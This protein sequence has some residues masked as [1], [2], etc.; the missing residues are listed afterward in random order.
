MKDKTGVNG[1]ELLPFH[2]IRVCI[3]ILIRRESMMSVYT[4]DLI[5]HDVAAEKWIIIRVLA[6]IHNDKYIC[7]HTYINIC[8]YVYIY[9]HDL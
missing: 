6:R 9:E 1:T 4:V 2:P 8:T 5:R 3:K 7:M